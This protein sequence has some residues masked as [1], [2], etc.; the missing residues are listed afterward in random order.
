M[1]L[2]RAV[3]MPTRVASRRWWGGVGGAAVGGCGGGDKERLWQWWVCHGIVRV[4][5]AQHSHGGVIRAGGGWRACCGV[6]EAAARPQWWRGMTEAAGV[7]LCC[8]GGSGIVGVRGEWRAWVSGH[9]V[10]GAG[11][12]QP[13]A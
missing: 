7:A 12:Q 4:A 6:G 3:A 2:K 13:Q 10:S 8:W 5:A 1:A 11:E 9:N